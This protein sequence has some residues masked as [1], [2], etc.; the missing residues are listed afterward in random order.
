MSDLDDWEFVDDED[1]KMTI[2]AA[3]QYLLKGAAGSDRGERGA[4]PE[5]CA[6]WSGSQGRHILPDGRFLF[7]VPGDQRQRPAPISWRSRHFRK[8]V[9]GDHLPGLRQIAFHL[10]KDWQVAGQSKK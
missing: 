9:S 4:G 5:P 6:R 8:R 2:R 3:V 1:A 10:P 7:Q